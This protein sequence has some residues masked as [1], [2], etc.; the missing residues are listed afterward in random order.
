MFYTTGKIKFLV[1]GCKLKWN[2]D[3]NSIETF[4]NRAGK[5]GITTPV[6]KASNRCFKYEG[7]CN[8]LESTPVEKKDTFDGQN[9]SDQSKTLSI[10]GLTHEFNLFTDEETTV[11]STRKNIRNEVNYQ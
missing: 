2:I 5:L 3:N 10:D 6:K 1:K 8:V 9:L 7:K 4:S 11:V